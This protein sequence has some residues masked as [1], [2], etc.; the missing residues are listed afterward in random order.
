MRTQKEY[1]VI[2]NGKR[3]DSKGFYCAHSCVS[4]WTKKEALFLLAKAKKY[5][6][7][8]Y[9]LRDEIRRNTRIFCN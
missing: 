3:I 7:N 1:I 4:A 5:Y 9:R 8:T 2:L 6:F